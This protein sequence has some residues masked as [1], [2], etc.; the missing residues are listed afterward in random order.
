MYKKYY[1]AIIIAFIMNVV[2]KPNIFTALYAIIAG[3]YGLF[4]AYC[5]FKRR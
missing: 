2:F 1:L 3:I 4:G 5:H